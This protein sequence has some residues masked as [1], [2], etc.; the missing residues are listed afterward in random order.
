MDNQS[1]DKLS[2]RSFV[3]R[4]SAVAAATVVGF[5]TIVPSR[6][7]GANAPSNRIN[8]GLVNKVCAAHRSG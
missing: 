1:K 7:L 4:A 2:R 8:V 6:V 5:P 3:R